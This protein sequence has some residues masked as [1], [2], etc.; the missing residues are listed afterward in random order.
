MC[1]LR[2][3]RDSLVDDCFMSWIVSFSVMNFPDSVGSWLHACS[4]V[5]TLWKAL[6]QKP[7]FSLRASRKAFIMR[8]VYFTLGARVKGIARPFLVIISFTKRNLSPFL[9]HTQARVLPYLSRGCTSSSR[10]TC[11]LR[12]SSALKAAAILPN[13]SSCLWG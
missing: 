8:S 1:P 11:F 7:L 5:K 10:N 13:S 4:D 3:M 12:T 2:S 6:P 9:S